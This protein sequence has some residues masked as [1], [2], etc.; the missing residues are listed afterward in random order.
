MVAYLKLNFGVPG[1]LHYN[2]LHPYLFEK[3]LILLLCKKTR[4]IKVEELSAEGE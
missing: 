1:Y 2:V 3:W 4:Q